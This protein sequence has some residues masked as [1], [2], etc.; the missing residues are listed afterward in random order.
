MSLSFFSVFLAGT[1]PT[2]H[3]I[4]PARVVVLRL[5]VALLGLQQIAMPSITDLKIGKAKA[6]FI[7]KSLPV[8]FLKFGI[9]K[10]MVIWGEK[11]CK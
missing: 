9:I 1:R 11:N 10:S 8:F 6:M 5:L 4:P 3:A 2:N 7:W